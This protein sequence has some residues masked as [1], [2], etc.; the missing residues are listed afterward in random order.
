MVMDWLTEHGVDSRSII[1][2]LFQV[3]VVLSYRLLYQPPLLNPCIKNV[4]L[5]SNNIQQHSLSEDITVNLIHNCGIFLHS[6]LR[7]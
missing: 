7:C 4:T 2:N 5:P 1:S 6:N 3:V